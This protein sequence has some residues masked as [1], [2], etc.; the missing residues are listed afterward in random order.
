MDS[1]NEDDIF[2]ALKGVYG[3]VRGAYACVAM[4]AG[5]FVQM[6]TW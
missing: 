5:N 1:V 6:F 3:Q 4:I 2:E